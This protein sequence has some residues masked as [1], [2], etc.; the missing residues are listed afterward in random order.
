MK[1]KD[2]EVLN[3]IKVLKKKDRKKKMKLGLYNHILNIIKSI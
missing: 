2:G 3:L 1:N